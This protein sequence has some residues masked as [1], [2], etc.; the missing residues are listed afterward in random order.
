MKDEVRD[1]SKETR[2]IKSLLKKVDV[3]KDTKVMSCKQLA[4]KYSYNI[5]LVTVEEFER[6]DKELEDPNSS[7]REDVVS[8]K[9]SRILTNNKP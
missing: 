3:P 4:E 7:L 6:F 1:V 5:P 2:T 9:N 8:F